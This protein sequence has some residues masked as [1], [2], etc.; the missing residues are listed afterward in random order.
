MNYFYTKPETRMKIRQ[1]ESNTPRFCGGE[2]GEE[3][4]DGRAIFYWSVLC[5]GVL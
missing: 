3:R 4:L 2:V 1:R 5:V